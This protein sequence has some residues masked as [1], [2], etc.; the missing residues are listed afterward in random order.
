MLCVIFEK[1]ESFIRFDLKSFWSYVNS[2]RKTLDIPNSVFLGA[3]KTE[4][5]GAIVRL[6]IAEKFKVSFRSSSPVLRP[7]RQV[8]TLIDN[9][10]I[11]NVDLCNYRHEKI[12]WLGPIKILNF[13]CFIFE[14]S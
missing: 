2:K 5:G 3:Q 10:R 6:F 9:A 8:A 14:Y 12:F 4:K 13:E 7:P 1:V 11:P